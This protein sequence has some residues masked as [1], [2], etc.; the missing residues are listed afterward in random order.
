M[1]GI[2]R[3]FWLFAKDSML[4]AGVAIINPDYDPTEAYYQKILI[5]HTERICSYDETRSELDCTRPRKGR[6]DRYIRDGKDDDG[7]VIVIKSSKSASV[8]CGRLGTLN[9]KP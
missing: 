2:R 8:I 5:T 6:G 7:E 4:N 1:H 9:P 3:K